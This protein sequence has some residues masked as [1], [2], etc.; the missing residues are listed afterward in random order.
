[1]K[2]YLSDIIRIGFHVGLIACMIYVSPWFFIIWLGFNIGLWL[3]WWRTHDE[4]KQ[5]IVR[6]I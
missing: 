1:M 3:G 4:H 6:V 2:I 5:V